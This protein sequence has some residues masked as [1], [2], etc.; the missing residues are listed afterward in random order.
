MALRR[1]M[2]GYRYTDAEKAELS[3][4]TKAALA[5]PERRAKIT[6]I[7]RERAATTDHMAMMTAALLAKRRA[8]EPPADLAKYYAKL[9]RCG[10]TRAA[11]RAVVERIVADQQ[12]ARVAEAAD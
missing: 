9:I 8:W 2:R 6:A 5:T 12:C 7:A 4:A 11:A 1:G 3:A 10:Y